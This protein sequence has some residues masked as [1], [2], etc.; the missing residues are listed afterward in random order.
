MTNKTDNRI[1]ITLLLINAVLFASNI[2]FFL[3]GAA[4][5]KGAASPWYEGFVESVSTT[6]MQTVIII[7]P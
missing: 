6:G 4:A 7:Q 1:A 2:V 3:E 5:L